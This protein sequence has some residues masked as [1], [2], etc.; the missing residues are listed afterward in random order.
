MTDH[1]TPRQA[2]VR[3]HGGKHKI[4]NWIVG[5]MP[6]HACYIEPFG[7]GAAVLLRKRSAKT[8]VYNDL[9]QEVYN[10][11]RTIRENADALA[12]ALY[13]TPYS[14]QEL[15]AAYEPT[16]DPL[17]AAR[18]FIVRSHMAITTT[19]IK[20]RSGF[21]AAINSGDYCS[22]VATWSKLPEVVHTVRQRF[23][24]V[25]LENCDAFDLF[26]RY[27]LPGTLW[28]LDPP[29]TNDSRSEKSVKYGYRHNLTPEQQV[30][31]CERIRRLK[32]PVMLSG[33]DNPTYNTLLHDWKKE[34]TKGFTDSHRKL[35]TEV[36]WMNFNRNL[37]F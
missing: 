14:R 1:A 24:R 23:S 9:D 13:L 22:Q 6:V 33:Y 16:G 18:R 3:Y 10:V 2:I 30:A 25:I 36:L 27:D 12:N 28:Y 21:R 34:Y 11:F 35:A 29:Y 8:E 19:S 5:K 31:L 4:A 15:Q 17:E 20:T 37:L 32:G 26:D 7:G